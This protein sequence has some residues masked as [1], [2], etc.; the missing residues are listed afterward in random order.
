D[1]PNQQRK[2]TYAQLNELLA[3]ESVE[4]TIK[5]L[6][7]D[8]TESNVSKHM[9][10][11]SVPAQCD[12]GE[13][14][15]Y[16]RSELAVELPVQQWLDEDDALHEDGVRERISEALSAAYAE[17]ESLAGAEALRTFEKQMLL[18]VLD[19]LWKEHLATMDH[20]RQGIHLRGYAQKNPK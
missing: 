12:I 7:Q 9:P 17:K 19:D 20:L 2:V 4:E 5:A 14:A 10:P 3:G 1:V 18:R 6:R 15:H 8:L 13:L 11:Q 16:L